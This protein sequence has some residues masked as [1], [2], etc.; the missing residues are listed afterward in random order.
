MSFQTFATFVSSPLVV[1]FK[2]IQFQYLVDPGPV[3][4]Q[5][6]ALGQ[7]SMVNQPTGMFFGSVRKPEILE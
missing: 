2:Y 1:A 7:F 3:V 5:S 6:L 4:E